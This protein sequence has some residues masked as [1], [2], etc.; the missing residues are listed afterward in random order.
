MRKAPIFQRV[1][2]PQIFGNL[3]RR[4]QPRKLKE[5]LEKEKPQKKNEINLNIIL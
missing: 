1:R 4:H 2:K 3:I 5:K